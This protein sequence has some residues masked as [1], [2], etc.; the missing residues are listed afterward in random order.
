MHVLRLLVALL[1]VWTALPLAVV[2]LFVAS[3]VSRRAGLWM[4]RKACRIAD[5]PYPL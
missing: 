2:A 4:Y 1:R 5:R 3:R